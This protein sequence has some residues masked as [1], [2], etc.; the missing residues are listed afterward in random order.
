MHYFD[1]LFISIVPLVPHTYFKS[2]CII[3]Y[4]ILLWKLLFKSRD[5]KFVEAPMK[6]YELL[7]GLCI[8][9]AA[10]LKFYKAPTI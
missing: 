7:N 1:I 6:V 10:F 2:V 8:L 3:C 9:C 5:E 4:V